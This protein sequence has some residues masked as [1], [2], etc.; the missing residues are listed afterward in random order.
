MTTIL[1]RSG[2]GPL[3]I[4]D[5]GLDS[6]ICGRVVPDGGFL[7]RWETVSFEEVLNGTGW[8]LC[9]R[10]AVYADLLADDVRRKLGS[11]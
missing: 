9:R 3:H 10:C 11:V 4:G 6:T 5:A 8:H 1:I 7:D 2:T